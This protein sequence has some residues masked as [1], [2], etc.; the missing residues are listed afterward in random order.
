MII[1][2]NGAFG[3]GKTRLVDELHR[4]RPDALVYDPEQTGF[5]LR[6]IVEVPTGD[7]QDLPLWRSQVAGMAV[8][9]VRA[10]GRPVL[11]PMTL[12]DPGYAEEI[13]GA[14]EAAGVKA[15]HFFLDVSARTLEARLDARVVAPGD[16][17]RDELAR[18]WCKA[19]IARCLAAAE[20]L[21][22]GTVRLDGERPTGE[23]ADE[24]LEYLA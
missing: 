24:V 2:V 11:A 4:R 23:L 6:N 17:E 12:V 22:P 10:Y 20:T 9:L 13:F 7:F 8:D 18:R 14:L 3:S 19:Q 5:V 1:W 15:H 21:R 16:P